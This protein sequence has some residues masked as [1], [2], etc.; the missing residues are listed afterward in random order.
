[1]KL[2]GK[3]IALGGLLSGVVALAAS[4]L[5]RELLPPQ[6]GDV[7]PPFPAAWQV[8]MVAGAVLLGVGTIIWMLAPDD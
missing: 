8:V 6:P 3:L 7:A 2:T 5:W 4:G 1:M